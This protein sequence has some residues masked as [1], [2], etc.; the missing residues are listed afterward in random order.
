MKNKEE[1]SGILSRGNPRTIGDPS[2]PDSATER[3]T[4]SPVRPDDTATASPEKP[5]PEF[6]SNV[7][8]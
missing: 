1:P 8:D 6:I 4:E 2:L 5:A 7:S 3:T